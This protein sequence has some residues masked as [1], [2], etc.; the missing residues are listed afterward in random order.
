MAIDDV[1]DTLTRLRLRRL[2]DEPAE[3]LAVLALAGI[4]ADPVPD[5]ELA[6]GCGWKNAVQVER[7]YF[8]ARPSF[9]LSCRAT[10]SL[11]LWE[12]HVVMPAAMR[13]FGHDW[14]GCG[15]HGT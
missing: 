3:C 8:A 2:D 15:V 13:H 4:A 11:L 5:K 1:P 7:S 10:V 14:L 6:S 9:L 12:R